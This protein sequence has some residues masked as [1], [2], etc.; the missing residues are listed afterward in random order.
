MPGRRLGAARPYWE[1][2]ARATADK[3]QKSVAEL[4]R[5][6]AGRPLSGDEQAGCRSPVLAALYAPAS[7]SADTDASVCMRT[8]QGAF[9]SMHVCQH[10][11]CLRCRRH[12]D[13][14][15]DDPLQ[16]PLRILSCCAVHQA[17][18][19]CMRSGGCAQALLS[20]AAWPT[21]ANACNVPPARCAGPPSGWRAMSASECSKAVHLCAYRAG[22][23]RI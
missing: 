20:N 1:L 10:R 8:A 13:G 6:L 3:P 23:R 11:R 19:L 16:L 4:I 12:G 15:V 5:R 9:T 21:A 17:T 14:L 18:A 2:L 22:F 7:Q